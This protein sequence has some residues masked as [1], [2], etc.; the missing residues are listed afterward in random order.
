MLHTRKVETKTVSEP[1]DY[2]AGDW[3]GR[4]AGSPKGLYFR[5]GLYLIGNKL[6]L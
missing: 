3:D 5:Y 1:D 6:D 2:Q 4:T